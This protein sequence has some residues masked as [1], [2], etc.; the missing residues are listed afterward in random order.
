MMIIFIF[1]YF[2]KS[3]NGKYIIDKYINL[4]INLSILNKIKLIINIIW[5]KYKYF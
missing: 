2:Y 4:F 5:L 3:K 1:G